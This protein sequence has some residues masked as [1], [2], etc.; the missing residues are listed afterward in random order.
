M[1]VMAIGAHFDDVELGCGGALARHVAEGDEVTILVATHSGYAGPAGNV[2]RDAG[3]ALAEGRAAAEIL[4]VRDLVALDFPTNDLPAGD[5][6]VCALLEA[7]GQRGI[8]QV[9]THWHG[10]AHLD[11]QNLARATISAC[12]HIKRL[13]MYRSNLYEGVGQ[14]RDNFFVDISAFSEIKMSAISAHHSEL[15]RVGN[16]WLD[17]VRYRDRLNGLRIGVESAEAFQVFR[18]IA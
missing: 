16:C 2:I 12:R 9:Y 4:G 3:T 6:V 7:I 14:F 15:G 1:K 5:R 13:L 8:D 11:H 17:S 18:Y 10:D